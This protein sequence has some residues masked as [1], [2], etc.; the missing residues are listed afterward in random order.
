MLQMRESLVALDNAG[1]HRARRWL[2][3]GVSMSVNPGEIVTLIG[4]NGSGKSTTAKMALGLLSPDEGHASRRSAL[5][6][7]YVPQKVS[8]D[9]TMPLT[10]SRF[11]R[12]TGHVG[13][14][15]VKAAMEATGVVHLSDAEV[16]TLSGGEFQRVMLARAMAR[17]PDL[18][19]LDEPVQGVDF[20]GEIALYDLIKRIRDE[21]HCGILLI[22]HDLHVVMAATDRV[23]CLNGHVCCSGTPGV[24]ASSAE[25]KALFGARAASTLAVYEHHHDHTHLPDGRVRHADGSLTDHCHTD[26]GHHGDRENQGEAQRDA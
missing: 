14:E 21:L 20:S 3:R 16:R 26:D 12:L 15:E 6:V 7:S 8:V 5:R 11:M 4:P 1:V 25:Y 23:I 10:V 22:S 18:L 9:W 24:V 13:K 17:K 19:V 2:V